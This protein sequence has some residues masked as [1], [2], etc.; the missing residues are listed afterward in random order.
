[1]SI[2]L[3]LVILAMVVHVSQAASLKFERELIQATTDTQDLGFICKNKE[4]KECLKFTTTDTMCIVA[5]VR[6]GHAG[7]IRLRMTLNT[8]LLV[9]GD[10]TG[11]AARSFCSRNVPIINIEEICLI[12]KDVDMA[13]LHSCLDLSVK[14]KG[15][16]Y[17][18]SIGCFTILGMLVQD[19]IGTAFVS[20][21]E[22]GIPINDSRT[23][24]FDDSPEVVDDDIDGSAIC[25][26]GIC[27]IC[28]TYT[29]CKACVIAKAVHNA[30]EVKLVASR[31]VVVKGKIANNTDVSFCIHHVRKHPDIKFVCIVARNIS[32]KDM[33]ACVNITVQVKQS[34]F[35]ESF[36]CF[37]IPNK[38]D[39][40]Q[41]LVSLDSEDIDVETDYMD[42]ENID[43][44]ADSFG[45]DKDDVKADTLE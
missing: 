16:T 18:N 3:N 14:Y 12:P 29:H 44:L 43:V 41:P 5:T 11:P 45:S 6:F 17:T 2:I 20:A 19:R 35:N 13:K 28:K 39:A 7:K 9:E 24:G 1:M 34:T 4:C 22:D 31:H 25:H 8:K 27:K 32:I 37:K 15:K 33:S 36:G 30:M 21:G 40:M 23:Y 42:S 26:K 38:A 10:I